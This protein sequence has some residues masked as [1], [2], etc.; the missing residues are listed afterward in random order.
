[1]KVDTMLKVKTQTYSSLER[2]VVYL[3]YFIIQIQLY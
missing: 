2:S 3:E 1:M